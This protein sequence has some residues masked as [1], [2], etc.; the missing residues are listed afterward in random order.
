MTVGFLFSFSSAYFNRFARWER[1]FFRRPPLFP[2]VASIQHFHLVKIV[3]QDKIRQYIHNQIDHGDGKSETEPIFQRIEKNNHKAQ[4]TARE[5]NNFPVSGLQHISFQIG[6]V[7]G[8]RH[9][10]FVKIGKLSQ[11]G[12]FVLPFTDF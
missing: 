2:L 10:I 8:F 12:H 5:M 11:L 1:L 7:A 3:A 4:K 9:F 6:V